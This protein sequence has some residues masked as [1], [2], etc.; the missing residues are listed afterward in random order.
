MARSRKGRLEASSAA[1]A[2]LPSPLHTFT[3]ATGCPMDG[4]A[5][6]KLKAILPEVDVVWEENE[7]EDQPEGCQM[8][9]SD[10]TSGLFLC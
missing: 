6:L 8:E 7:E 5:F 10:V 1:Q 4:T 3:L 2:D 9:V